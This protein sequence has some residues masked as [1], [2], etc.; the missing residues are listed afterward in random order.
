[1]SGAK[2]PSAPEAAARRAAIPAAPTRQEPNKSDPKYPIYDLVREAL[3][4]LPSMF[5]SE[6]NITGVL[7]TD[8]FTFNSALGASI[9]DQIVRALNTPQ[10]RAVWDPE[11]RWLSLRFARRSQSFPDV[12]LVDDKTPAAGP[13]LGIE[14]KG[15]FV[16]SREGE[17]SF[18]YKIT[19]KACAPFDLVAVFPW[20]L[21][22]AV[23][24]RPHL[25]APYIEN[26]AYLAEYRNWYWRWGMDGDAAT[27]AGRGLRLSPVTTP[28]PSKNHPADDDAVDDKGRNFGRIARAGV[29]TEF[30]ER[31]LNELLLGV[32]C[33][34]WLLFLKAH[35]SEAKP[36]EVARVLARLEAAVVGSSVPAEKSEALR[37][38]LQEIVDL[39]S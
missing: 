28:Y 20:A 27:E 12:V 39:L 18:R 9:E 6:I 33:S 24:G 22:S 8:L 11:S 31:Q 17:P 3:V 37:A 32:P 2:K 16:L 5:E 19:P 15:W 10:I 30:V 23:A 1:M 38:R 35:A 26:A 34:S 13:V 7:A 36:D 21:S 14:L 25:Y 4:S 29:M